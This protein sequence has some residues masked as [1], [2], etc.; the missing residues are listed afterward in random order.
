M[1]T[2]E[3]APVLETWNDAWL[4]SRGSYYTE[5]SAE[6]AT[7]LLERNTNNRPPK[8]RSIA[9]FAR[10]MLAK[11]WD[12]DA[13][14]IKFDWNGV[15][16]DG[17]NRL[18][19]CM[20]SEASF[21]TLVRTGL[22]PASKRH[23]D[24]GTKRTVADMLRMEQVE[25]KVTSIGAAVT[26]WVRYADRVINFNGKRLANKSGGGRPGQQLFLTHD[27]ILDFL[28]KHP[29]IKAMASLG[30]SVRRQAMPAI[31]SSAILCF[32]AMA[33]EKD[34]E[35][36]RRFAE[37]LINGEITGPGDPMIALMQYAAR[38]QGKAGII[39][40]PGHRGRIA[41]E[42]HLHAMSRVWNATRA[43]QKIDGRLHIKITDR[44]V[45]PQ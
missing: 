39:G 28:Q 41:Q 37:R 40:S 18:I 15:L 29:T 3:K 33:A 36:T 14:D 43:G 27:E 25:G 8:E 32:L 12:P 22:N 11:R 19:A 2:K 9:Q 10:D 7:R 21:P 26:L 31:P 30:E 45:M 35:E 6:L 16:F 5:I 20:L 4:K 1:A 24:T 42:S 17:Q 13:S 23:V 38:I 34:E 44:L